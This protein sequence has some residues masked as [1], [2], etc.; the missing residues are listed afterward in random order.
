MLAMQATR[1]GRQTAV[2]PS[3]ASQLPQVLQCSQNSSLAGFTV[4][5][6]LLAMQAARSGRQTAVMPSQASQLPQVLQCLQNP[7]LAGFTV[8][9]GLLAMQ[10]T[11]S[12]RQ[13]AVMPSQASH[14]GFYVMPAA[15]AL[16]HQI[17]RRIGLLHGAVI[18]Q[19]HQHK[20]R[21]G[22]VF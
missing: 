4:G 19:G 14:T 5:A 3:Q 6:G 17:A 21:F 22:N 11:R 15:S 13:T 12:G 16:M 10:A 20:Q 1:S 7:S 8:G 9:A 2:M 18:A